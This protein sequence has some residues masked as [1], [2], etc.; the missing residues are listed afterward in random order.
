MLRLAM[1]S[2]G[3]DKVIEIGT[4][5]LDVVKLGALRCFQSLFLSKD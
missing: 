1:S 2:S 3:G 4:Y 5:D